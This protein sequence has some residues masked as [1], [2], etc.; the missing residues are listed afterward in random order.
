MKNVNKTGYLKGDQNE[1][2]SFRERRPT[3]VVENTRTRIPS[4]TTSPINNVSRGNCYNL[5]KFKP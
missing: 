5:I 4:L 2:N 1:V 3:T